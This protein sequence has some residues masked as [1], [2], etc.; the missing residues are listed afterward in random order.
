MN[1]LRIAWLLPVSFFYWQPSLSRL[2][3]LFPQTTV[4]AAYWPGLAQGFENH[5]KVK[6][7]GDNSN[8]RVKGTPN[9]NKTIDSLPLSIVP[10]LLKFKPNIIFS[11]SFGVWTILALLFKF[12]GN[13]RVII[14]YEGSSPTVDYR[15]S[16]AR[17]LVRKIMVKLADSYI[18]NSQAGKKYLIE[19]LGASKERVF[20]QPYEVPNC[21]ALL[22]KSE[23][24]EAEQQ[25]AKPVFMFIGHIVPRKGLQFLLQ[26]CVILKQQGYENYT[27]LLVG[28][29]PQRQELEAFSESHGLVERIQWVGRVEYGRLGAYFRSSDVFVLPTLEDT[30]GVVVQ[31]AMIMGKPV[32]C[33]ERAGANELI[34]QGENGYVFDPEK[35]EQLAEIMRKF[36]DNPNLSDVMGKKSEQAMANIT[37]VAAGNF[38]A[39]VAEFTWGNRTLISS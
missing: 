14:A 25:L 1:D 23:V 4:F 29:G 6:L 28:D 8:G 7:V 26:A 21:V 24:N 38:L 5:V 13:W 10:E 17:L 39:Q 20:A 16:P 27:L 31:E 18:T 34:S 12:L 32:L 9:Y 33:S 11:N 22:E 30:W 35:P 2:T 36:I 37:P 3:E 19:V 15:N